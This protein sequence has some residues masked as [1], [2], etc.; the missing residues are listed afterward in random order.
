MQDF[1]VLDTPLGVVPAVRTASFGD[2]LGAHIIDQIILGVIGSVLLSGLGFRWL[3]MHH[4]WFRDFFEMSLLQLVLSAVYYIYFE[5]SNKRAIFGKQAMGLEV[6]DLEGNTLTQRDAIFR[7]FAKFVSRLFLYLGYFVML[8]SSKQ[9]TLHD[10][11][12]RALV[13]KKD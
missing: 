9:Q 7:Y 6:V 10:M 2:R 3:D 8:F 4:Y 1:S 11:F 12:A 13:V 5:T